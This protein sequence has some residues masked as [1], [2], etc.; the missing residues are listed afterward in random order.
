MY[1]I[2]MWMYAQPVMVAMDAW[3]ASH[4][5]RVCMHAT[6]VHA[7]MRPCAPDPLPH[8]QRAHERD[9]PDVL[10]RRHI[11]RDLDIVHSVLHQPV[12]DLDKHERPKHRDEERAEL[13]AED[14]QRQQALHDR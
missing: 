1:A 6:F 11:G 5:P 2:T 3:P 9:E 8:Q 10:Q 4:A 13:L 14:G 12:H 7:C